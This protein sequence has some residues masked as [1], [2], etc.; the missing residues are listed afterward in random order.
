MKAIKLFI[1][2]YKAE[3]YSLLSQIKMEVLGHNPFFKKIRGLYKKDNNYQYL[4]LKKEYI[5][6]RI[7]VE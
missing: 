7:C 5:T 6:D 1:K 2:K 3:K 4:P